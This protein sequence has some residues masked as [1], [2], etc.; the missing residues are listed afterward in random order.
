MRYGLLLSLVAVG[1]VACC[2]ARAHAVSGTPWE[3]GTLTAAWTGETPDF[4][5]GTIHIVCPGGIVTNDHNVDVGASF[6]TPSKLDMKATTSDDLPAIQALGPALNAK[7]MPN[8]KP[9]AFSAYCIDIGQWLQPGDQTYT[10]SDAQYAPTGSGLPAM[11]YLKVKDLRILFQVADSVKLSSSA[12][13]RQASAFAAAVWE[14]VNEKPK[15]GYDITSGNFSV[16]GP[17]TA[18]AQ[19]LL[20]AV[21]QFKRDNPTFDP[22]ALPQIYSLSS[23][24]SQD[25]AIVV[26]SGVSSPPIPEPITLLTSLIVVSGLGC[27]AR[28]RKLAAKA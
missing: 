26:T 25:F 20:D 19:K 23:A 8:G 13:N 1:A 5:T 3:Y 7:L 14:I 27:Y 11:G 18:D 9:A 21:G 28:R 17:M 12:A 24:T 6:F 4:E 2:V 22:E 15:N 10:I 16:D